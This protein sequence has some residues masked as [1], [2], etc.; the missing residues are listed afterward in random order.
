MENKHLDNR[1][2]LDFVQ[3]QSH[4]EALFAMRE[5]LEEKEKSYTMQYLAG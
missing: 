1:R 3:T 5:L 2:I 4:E